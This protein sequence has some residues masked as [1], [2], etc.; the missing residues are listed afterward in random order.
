MPYNEKIADKIRGALMDVKNLTEKKMFG[1]IAFMINDKMCVGVVK[2]EMMCRIN[3]EMD[4]VVLEMND[5]R[6]MDFTGK[7]MKSYVFV[8]E[9]GMETK[10]SF[11]YWINL[12]LEFNVLA[13]ASKKN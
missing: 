12:C 9:E 6:A 2:D 5:C 13:K 4:E 7:R 10:K 11:D 3:P 1:G 8:S